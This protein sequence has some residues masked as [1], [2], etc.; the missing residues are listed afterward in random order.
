VVSEENNAGDPVKE[1]E[2]PDKMVCQTIL[3]DA[4]QS[5]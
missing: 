1:I 2:I 4:W 3:L 5:I